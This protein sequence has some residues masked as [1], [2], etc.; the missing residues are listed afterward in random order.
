MGRNNFYIVMKYLV[1][2][3]LKKIEYFALKSNYF[4]IKVL[5]F[6]FLFLST[7]AHIHLIH[8]PLTIVGMG[9]FNLSAT[10][11]SIN[12]TDELYLPM[13]E[14]NFNVSYSS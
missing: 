14:S 11:I 1:Q 5:E 7:S 10:Y 8:L 13:K 6:Y 3:F 12:Y 4:A 2:D 9:N